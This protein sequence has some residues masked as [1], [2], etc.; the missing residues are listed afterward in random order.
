MFSNPVIQVQIL[1]QFLIPMIFMGIPPLHT[2][3]LECCPLQYAFKPK[4]IPGLQIKQIPDSIKLT[5]IVLETL[6]YQMASIMEVFCILKITK[7]AANKKKR[8]KTRASPV[9]TSK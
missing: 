9:I 2:G 5:Y 3:I 4:N 1:A 6:L 7:F 8:N